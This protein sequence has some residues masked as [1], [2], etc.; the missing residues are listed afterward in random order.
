M[1][2]GRGGSYASN[3]ALR[4][5]SHVAYIAADNLTVLLFIVLAKVM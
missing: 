5:L 2:V 1:M 4:V 3:D